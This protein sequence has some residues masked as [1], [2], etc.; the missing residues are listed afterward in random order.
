MRYK[1][2]DL[3]RCRYFLFTRNQSYPYLLPPTSGA[4]RKHLD[5]THLQLN[6]WENANISTVPR[7]EPTNYGWGIDG[8]DYV[9]VTTDELIAP[10]STIELVSYNCKARCKESRFYACKRSEENCTDVCG[11]TNSD[12]GCE[13]KD[14]VLMEMDTDNELEKMD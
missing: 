1:I 7:L 5:Q 10:V 9:P 13:N 8:E 14:G 12:S 6:I 11:C 3:T 4:F 2:G